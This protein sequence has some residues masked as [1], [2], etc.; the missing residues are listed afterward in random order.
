MIAT[1][2]FAIGIKAPARFSPQVAGQG[3]ALLDRARTESRIVEKRL[4]ERLSGGEV[5]VNADQIHELK[6]T[7]RETSGLFHDSVDG[8]HLGLAIPKD[9][10][11]L[12]VKRPGD[13]VDDESRG[14]LGRH[15]SLAYLA[16]DAYGLFHGCRAGSVSPDDLDQG[17]ER[18]RVKE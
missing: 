6:R 13:A 16:R 17:H 18:R 10:Q 1:L 4:M 3:H 2:F 14:V 9:A 7:H 12:V 15:R 8:L 5:D 11:R